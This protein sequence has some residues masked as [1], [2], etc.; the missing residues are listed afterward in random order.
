V[1]IVLDDPGT[2][3]LA[4]RV[5]EF[6]PGREREAGH[7]AVLREQEGGVRHRLV[8]DDLHARV[9]RVVG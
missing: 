8:T 5:V 1:T 6:R 9:Y 3:A 7:L 4:E 2:V